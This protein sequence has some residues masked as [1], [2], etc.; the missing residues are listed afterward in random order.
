MK[1]WPILLGLFATASAHAAALV[2]DFSDIDFW[3][4]T[5]PNYAAILIDWQDGKTAP[6]EIESHALVW[7]YRWENGQ[8]PKGIDALMA[9]DA[10]DPRLEIHLT[11]F[12]SVGGTKFFFG[13]FYDLDDDGGTP[14]FDPMG[15]TG[16]ASDPDD[17]FQE[18]I[19]INGY[20]RYLLGS[21]SELPESWTVSGSG[22]SIRT[23]S[24]ESWDAWVFSDYAI[25]PEPLPGLAAAAQPVP[26]PSSIVLALS[27]LAFAFL[28]RR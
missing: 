27:G 9:I 28:R 11:S 2:D 22:A 16:F 5:G 6:G 12:G 14:T 15:E 1:A 10:A 23:L 26:E 25:T 4:G 24:H 18:G 3:V 17:H 20:W 7:G 19:R 21:G 8:S 13:A